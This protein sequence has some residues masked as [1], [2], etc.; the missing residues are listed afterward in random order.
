MSN[1]PSRP[2]RGLKVLQCNLRRSIVALTHVL[3]TGRT[4]DI[5]VVL[6]QDLPRMDGTEAMTWQG[7][8][9]IGVSGPNG[10]HTEAGLF[11]NS[12]LQFSQ[13]PESTPRSVGI[14]LQWENHN[15]GIVSGYLQ[16]GTARGLP[17]LAEL[18]QA[19]KART[20]MVFVGADV[21]GHSPSWG[22]LET[23]P[24]SQGLL[25]ED[26]ILETGF[27]VLNCPNSLATFLPSV[28]LG[29]WIDVSLATRPLAALMVA[30]QF[31]TNIST[32]TIG[33]S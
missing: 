11:L 15:L 13:S 30:G 23:V 32:A 33:P 6:V 31:W 12:Q 25:V 10:T 2:Q 16:P 20:P 17:E 22:P 7:H 3:D 8:T 27:E 28:G 18:C 24:N 9:F 21:N 4:Q 5:D 26:F 1:R 29:T 19:L 14:E